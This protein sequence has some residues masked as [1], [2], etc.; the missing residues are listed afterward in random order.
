MPNRVSH[1]ELL[2]TVRKVSALLN[3]CNCITKTQPG[4][5]LGRLRK[6]SGLSRFLKAMASLPH[7]TDL[8]PYEPMLKKRLLK[9]QHRVFGLN[10]GPLD[11]EQPGSALANVLRMNHAEKLHAFQLSCTALLAAL[12][13]VPPATG[14]LQ[15]VSQLKSPGWRQPKRK[16]KL[17]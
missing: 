3:A 1:G 2:A 8:R 14:P 4:T 12:D 6:L 13:D 16:E 9:A 7:N 15:T 5:K 17:F 10:P 11:S